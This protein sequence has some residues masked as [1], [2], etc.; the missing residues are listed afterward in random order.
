MVTPSALPFYP[1]P[2]SVLSGGAAR[3]E[4]LFEERFEA[5]GVE[6][7]EDVVAAADGPRG[8]AHLSGV[9]GGHGHDGHV[10]RALVLAYPESRREAVEHGHVQ[11]HQDEVKSA[12]LSTE[13]Q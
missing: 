11:V 9:V 1:F 8:G 12:L 13:E 6:R 3:G 10:A 2:F 4:Q 7:L 5:R